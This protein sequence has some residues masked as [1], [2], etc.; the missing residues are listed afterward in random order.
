MKTK[1]A[2]L[3]LMISSILW[4]IDH[5]YFIIKMIISHDYFQIS[6]FQGVL[7]MFVILVPI[8]L[9]IL[10]FSLIRDKSI[11]VSN[12]HENKNAETSNPT[13]RDWIGTFLISS[14]PILGLVFLIIWANDYNNKIRKNWAI[15]I[16]ILMSIMVFIS[17]LIYGI[18][19]IKIN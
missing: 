9:I 2:A 1:S 11:S 6:N 4:L 3:I 18:Y 8:S 17:L 12:Q 7:N 16:L 13:I 19:F 14:I 10:S 15:A 5:L